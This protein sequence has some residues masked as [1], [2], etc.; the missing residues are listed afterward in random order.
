MKEFL[1]KKKKREGA[2]IPLCF[3]YNTVKE[4][5]K[6]IKPAAKFI[7]TAIVLY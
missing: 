5:Y 4:F 1:T 6:K 2:K 3:V 7:V